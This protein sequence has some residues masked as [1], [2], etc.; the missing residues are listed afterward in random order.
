M[1]G[2]WPAYEDYQARTDRDIPVVVLERE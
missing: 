2:H 1:V